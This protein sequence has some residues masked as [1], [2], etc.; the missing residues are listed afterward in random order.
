MPT[1][2][3]EPKQQ[4]NSEKCEKILKTTLESAFIEFE[5]STEAANEMITNLSETILTQVKKMN[6]D[7]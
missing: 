5:Y 7:R 2:R 3:L 4:F 1:Y 6:F